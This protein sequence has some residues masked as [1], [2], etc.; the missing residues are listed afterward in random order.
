[1]QQI[2]RGHDGDITVEDS[3]LG[4]ACFRFFLPQTRNHIDDK[5]TR[6]GS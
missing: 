1:V 4:G 5:T 3:P 2:I 6:V